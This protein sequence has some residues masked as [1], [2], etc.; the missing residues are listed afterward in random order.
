TLAFSP[1]GKILAS[2]G[3]DKK[4]RLWE[5]ATGKQ[6]HNWEYHQRSLPRLVFSRD[7]KLLASCEDLIRVWQV[8]TG[9]EVMLVSPQF[10]NVNAMAFSPS[11]RFLAS[12]D[13]KYHAL[14]T[15]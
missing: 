1:N 7:S 5:V 4:L 14:P 6:L 9:Q 10:G 8:P 3:D 2:A 13:V 15:G 12:S 11:G